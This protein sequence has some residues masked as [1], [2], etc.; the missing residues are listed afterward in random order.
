MNSET[1]DLKSRR[2]VLKLIAGAGGA[3][4]ILLTLK[5]VPVL[6]QSA[7]IDLS[8]LSPA[9][10][11]EHEA[12]AS[13]HFGI[14]SKLLSGK[15]QEFAI[16]FQSDHK[17]HRDGIVGAIRTLGGEPAGPKKE[18]NFGRIKSDADF[19]RL[20]R[21]YELDFVRAYSSLAANVQNKGV[22]NFAAY[23]LADEVRHLTVWNHEL[24]SPNYGKS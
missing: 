20:V 23:I 13:Y 9:L 18:F 3:G 12:I 16:A 1:G 14:D 6:A 17:Y 10:Y 4:L 7:G 24:G 19:A 21:G 22:L 15:H 11:L 5:P 2:E 8:I